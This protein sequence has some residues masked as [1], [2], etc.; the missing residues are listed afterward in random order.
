MS[1]RVKAL[2][3]DGRREQEERSEKS[4]GNVVN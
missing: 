4:D 3:E 1:P 2:M